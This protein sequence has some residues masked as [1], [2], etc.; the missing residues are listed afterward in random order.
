MAF[1]RAMLAV[2]GF[3]EKPKTPQGVLNFNRGFV[4][5]GAHTPNRLRRGE[6]GICERKRRIPVFTLHSSQVLLIQNR[7]PGMQDI[8][9]RHA[10][11]E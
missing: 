10:H 7:L 9:A 4:E 6:N 8:L 2:Y 5:L 11:G 3:V 1:L